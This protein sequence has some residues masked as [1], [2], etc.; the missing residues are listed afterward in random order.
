MAENVHD[1]RQGSEEEPDE[2]TGEIRQ[3]ITTSEHGAP[4]AG[5]AVYDMFA[6][7]EIFKRIIAT[8]EE[9]Y[10]TTN[11][12]L[13]MSGIAAGATISL[14]FLGVSVL[15][16]GS[17]APEDVLFHSLLYPLGFIF[18]VLGRYQLFTENTLTPVTLVLTRL[19]SLP[20][21]LRIWG[22][23]YAANIMG[24]VLA[25]FF[26]ANGGIYDASVTEVA[27]EIGR[28]K[29]EEPWHVVFNSGI[30]AGWLVAGMV[31]LNHAATSTTARLLIVFVLTYTLSAAELAHCIVGSTEVLYAIFNGEATIG[32]YLWDFLVPATLGNTVGG[33]LLVGIL[34]YSR[35]REV[36][37]PDADVLSWKEWLLGEREKEQAA[38]DESLPEM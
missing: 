34:N 5:E 17:P 15:A 30:L 7:E 8:A 28:K 32:A 4:A 24:T 22:I 25:A 19:A 36:L 13:F 31:W 18:V 23:V 38:Q 9:E 33:V 3:A 20:R 14:S 2:V 37:F 6:A 11:R 1:A 10:S 21:L 27:L 16:A 12:L 29:V 35:T 26:F